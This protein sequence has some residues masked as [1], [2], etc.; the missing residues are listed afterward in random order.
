MVRAYLKARQTNPRF[1]GSG[2]PGFDLHSPLFCG[3]CI[4]VVEHCAQLYIDDIWLSK[5]VCD[6]FDYYR[7]YFMTT[8]SAY[9]VHVNKDIMSTHLSRF[10]GP[11]PRW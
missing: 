9:Q 5:S 11:P 10:L 7:L 6:V 2:T 1:S 8:L 4:F 3:R